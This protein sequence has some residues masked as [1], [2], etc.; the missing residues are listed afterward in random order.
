MGDAMIWRLAENALRVWS[1]AEEVARAMQNAGRR[2]G[3]ITPSQG[4]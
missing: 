2:G 1:E 3:M 4:A